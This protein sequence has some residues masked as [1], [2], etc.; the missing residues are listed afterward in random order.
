[1]IRNRALRRSVAATLMMGGGLL[2]L[3]APSVWV[4]VAPFLLGLAVEAIGIAVEH[5]S[6][7][8]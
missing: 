3:L 8:G 1:M 2:I 6:G 5:R 4:G 7:P